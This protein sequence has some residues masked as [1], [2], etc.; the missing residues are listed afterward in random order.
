MS[1]NIWGNKL[2]AKGGKK[3]TPHSGIINI[4]ITGRRMNEFLQNQPE[5]NE[6]L[7]QST[8]T[9]VQPYFDLLHCTLKVRALSST[10][11]TP[12]HLEIEECKKFA[13]YLFNKGF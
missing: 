13:R 8:I 3:E 11:K 4:K 1:S 12:R 5:F 7:G 9:M 2:H 6:F 10:I